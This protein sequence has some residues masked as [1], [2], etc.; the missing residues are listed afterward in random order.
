M[1]VDSEAKEELI[2]AIKSFL[3]NKNNKKFEF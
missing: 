1:P 3:R 2:R